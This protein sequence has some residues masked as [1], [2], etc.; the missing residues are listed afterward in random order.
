M[1]KS[2]TE[3]Q[4]PQSW[5]DAHISPVFKKGSKSQR[6]NYRPINLTSVV[7]KQMEAIIRD[8]ITTHINTNGLLSNC[9]H[10]FVSG[11][12]CSTQLISCLDKWTQ[13]LD[14]SHN[15]DTV[16]LDFSKAFDSVPHKILLVKM[17]DYGITGT[18]LGLHFLLDRRQRVVINGERSAWKRVI[19]GVPQGSVIGPT[20]S[21]LFI[22]DM[23]EV[24]TSCIEMFADDAK[25][26]KAI[27]TEQ[28][29]N[30]LQEDLDNLQ[31]WASTWEMKFNADKCKV[32]HIGNQNPQYEFQ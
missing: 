6:S 21:V 22:N 17:E 32:L 29:R 1:Q 27:M 31:N 12:S 3:E 10:G 24:V 11:R 25:V 20:M 28:D 5:K 14:Q 16:Y 26:F 7:C 19:S 9:K 30:D 8:H 2:L 4:L 23:P 13:E 15:V 18:I